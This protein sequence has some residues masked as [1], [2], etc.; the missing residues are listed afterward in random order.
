VGIPA[1]LDIYVVALLL[2]VVAGLLLRFLR[3]VLVAAPSALGVAWALGYRPSTGVERWV[4]FTERSWAGSPLGP[5]AL[6]T[7][8]GTVFVGGALAGVLMT[9]PLRAFAR[10]R[11]A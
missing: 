4:A 1:G 5:A 6:F 2:G 9:T 3:T 7:I 11:L 8:V 10:P